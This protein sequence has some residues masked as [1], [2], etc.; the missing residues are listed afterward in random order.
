MSTV[1][2]D[3]VPGLVFEEPWCRCI[4]EDSPALY[5]YLDLRTFFRFALE[6]PI[7]KPPAAS[8]PINNS[9]SFFRL[10]SS[11]GSQPVHW[12]TGPKTHRLAGIAESF[13]YLSSGCGHASPALLVRFILLYLLSG[14]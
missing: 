3:A 6:R 8:L 12:G 13:L 10:R 2:E 1:S 9:H 4:L 11:L 5:R 7:D 14:S